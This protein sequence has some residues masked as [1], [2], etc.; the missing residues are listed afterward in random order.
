MEKKEVM[1]DCLETLIRFIS[2][3]TAPSLFRLTTLNNIPLL[4][5]QVMTYA[6][7]NATTLIGSSA[8]AK[9]IKEDSKI[10]L[11]LLKALSDGLILRQ[12]HSTQK[13]EFC[14]CCTPP[15]RLI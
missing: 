1:Y 13:D 8:L 9:L 2:M 12:K 11:S 15:I 3:D 10:G 14:T 5:D 6:M 7:D 4:R